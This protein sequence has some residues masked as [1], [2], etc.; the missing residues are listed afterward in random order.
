MR[1][2]PV[3]RHVT[4]WRTG[5]VIAVAV[6]FLIPPLAWDRVQTNWVFPIAGPLLLVAV[7]AALLQP[8][9]SRLRWAMT[10]VLAGSVLFF[11][12]LVVWFRFFY[13]SS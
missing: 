4:R 3:W 5:L 6:G 8:R 1:L 13:N 9:S 7:L 11:A 2:H 12:S 10:A